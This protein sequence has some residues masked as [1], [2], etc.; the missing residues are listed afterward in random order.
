MPIPKVF[1][2]RE[3]KY[4]LTNEAAYKIETIGPN[5]GQLIQKLGFLS[6]RTYTDKAGVFGGRG[7]MVQYVTGKD[8]RNRDRGKYVTI[9]QSHNAIITRE[10]EVDIYGKEWDKFIS[11]SPYCEGSPNGDYAVDG[12]GNKTQINAVYRLLN[13]EGDAE[14]AM[15]ASIRRSKAQLSA[16]E[17]DDQ[18]LLE[19]ATIGL[20][21]TGTPGKLMRHEVIE[22]AGKRPQDYFDILNSG[23]RQVRGMVRKAIADNIF[24]QKGDMIYWGQTLI[25]TDEDKAVGRLIEDPVML[26]ALKEKVDLRI[27]SFK[28]LDSKKPAKAKNAK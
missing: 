25:G 1:E 26:D 2:N 19:V 24:S 22:W 21:R 11:N 23:D 4:V 10:G 15:E 18:I 14:V 3:K 12:E 16:A 7:V 17:I 28:K 9:N 20:G 6:F 8:D 13:T 27:E 5:A